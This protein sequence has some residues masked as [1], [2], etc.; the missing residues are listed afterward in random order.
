MAAGAVCE[1]ICSPLGIEPPIFRRR[2]AFY[3]KNRSFSVD[4]ARQLLGYEPQVNLEAGI[5][6]TADWYA[7]R[8]LLGA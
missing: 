5:K 2:V 3:T 8:G 6:A 1:A 7:A 4:K